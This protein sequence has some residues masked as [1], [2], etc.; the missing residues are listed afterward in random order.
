MSRVSGA[1]CGP[2][3]SS[4]TLRRLLT[5]GTKIRK[6]ISCSGLP[7]CCPAAATAATLLEL[8]T[9]LREVFTGRGEGPCQENQGKSPNHHLVMIFA[10]PSCLLTVFKLPLSIVSSKIIKCESPSRHFQQGEEARRG[11]FFDCLIF[12]DLRSQLYT[13]LISLSAPVSCCC[14]HQCHCL[15]HSAAQWTQ[16]CCYVS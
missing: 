8:S 13:R 11:L 7:L 14:C 6:H 12:A 4:P 10:S 16:V 9:N 15:H 2:C 3:L 5:V 1:D